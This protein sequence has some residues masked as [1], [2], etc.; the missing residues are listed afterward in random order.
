MMALKF[1]REAY[2]TFDRHIDCLVFLAI[3]YFSVEKGTFS[4]LSLLTFID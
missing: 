4:L 2:D 1:H 3:G